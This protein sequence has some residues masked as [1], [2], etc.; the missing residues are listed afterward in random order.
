[1]KTR[2][3]ATM[4]LFTALTAVGA[5]I[6]IPVPV[7]PFTLQF[8]FTMLAGILL[9]GKKGALSV[10]CYVLMGLAGLPIFAD[11]G[12]IGYIVH[13][14]F[15]YLIGFVIA[16]YVTNSI[17]EKSELPLFRRILA[18]NFTGLVIVY[19]AGMIW[20]WM[21]SRFYMGSPIGLYTLFLYCFVLA[22]PGDIFLC[23]VAAL[24]GKRLI[25]VLQKEGLCAYEKSA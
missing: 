8:L 22:V 3:L 18:A 4:A 25:P 9:G 23:I 7:V 20:Y 10:L 21:I 1:M 15:G 2:D 13:P 17:V 19:S 12:G 16:T 24:L 6:R 14:T 5:F 11:G